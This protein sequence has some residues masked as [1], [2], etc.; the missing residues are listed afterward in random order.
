VQEGAYLELVVAVASGAGV[1]LVPECLRG[2]VKGGIAFRKLRERSTTQ[3]TMVWPR[4][5][6]SVVLHAFLEHVRANPREPRTALFVR[7][8][9][10]R[11][12]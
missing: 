1:A 4:E 10:P 11:Q 5:S 6:T 7:N 9:D 3:V 8:C 2:V 12:E